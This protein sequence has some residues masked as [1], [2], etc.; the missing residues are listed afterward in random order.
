[1]QT[2]TI[3]AARV[4]QTVKDWVSRIDDELAHLVAQRN[5]LDIL[6][7]LLYRQKEHLLDAITEIQEVA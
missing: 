1:L 6:M 5:S 2:A 3:D 4:E 7:A